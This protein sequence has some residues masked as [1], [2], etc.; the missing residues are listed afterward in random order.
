MKKQIRKAE[1]FA[2]VVLSLD[3]LLLEGYA[4][5]FATFQ[6]YERVALE[7]AKR[8]K[9]PAYFLDTP[10][11]FDHTTNHKKLLEQQGLSQEQAMVY[12]LLRT[13]HNII[14]AVRG[15]ADHEKMVLDL[16]PAELVNQTKR[17]ESFLSCDLGMCFDYFSQLLQH[18]KGDQT[19][20]LFAFGPR[21]NYY[22]GRVRESLIYAPR[23]QLA[24][25]TLQGKIGVVVGAAH[26]D[27]L[28]KKLTGKPVYELPDW[29]TYVA[30]LPEKDQLVPLELEKI[31]G[32]KQ[33]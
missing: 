3:H 16:A 12:M 7:I 14:R 18:F 32:E 24:R 4:N 33:K 8:M 30:S 25:E 20:T 13:F 10:N 27:F 26:V 29:K 23:I 9:V 11:F 5:V 6:N 31:I 15:S 22:F 28:E 2:D 17:Y 19:D 21:F 1:Q